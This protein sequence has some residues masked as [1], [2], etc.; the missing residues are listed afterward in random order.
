VLRYYNVLVMTFPVVFVGFCLTQYW[1]EYVPR[2]FGAAPLVELT[3]SAVGTH[4]A[5]TMVFVLAGYRKV[6]LLWLLVWFATFAIVAA[7]NRGATLAVLIPVVF[8]M[9]MLGRLRLL[10]MTMLAVIGV[11]AVL[12]AV[13]ASFMQSD[14]TSRSTKRMVSAHQIIKNAESIVG[15]SGQLSVEGT[16]RWR[17]DWWDIIIKDTVY[18]PNFWTGRGFGLNLAEADG[19]AGGEMVN[20]QP[21]APTRSPHNVNMTILAR[22]GVPGLVLWSLLLVFWGGMMLH[23]MLV[24]Y[25]RGHKQWANLFLFV[26]CYETSI[27]INAFVDV[28]IEGPMQ[29]IWFWCLFGYGIG[30]VM[31][32]RVRPTDRM[33]AHVD[34]SL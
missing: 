22:A 4:L 29:G 16:K 31:V 1:V 15:D 13:E 19:R 20:G 10:K 17:L 28:T 27:I 26:V 32:Y 33:G 25:I 18:G 12:L 8:S 2:L 30:S 6:S 11:F 34:E 23:A 7:T 3:T 5:G 14:E 21:R 9:L 24:A